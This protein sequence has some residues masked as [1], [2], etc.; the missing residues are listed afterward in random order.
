MGKNPDCASG[1][2]LSQ[3]TNHRYFC[4]RTRKISSCFAQSIGVFPRESFAFGF[5]PWARRSWMIS[6]CSARELAVPPAPV[7]W[8]AR[9]SG[10]EPFSLRA[11]T[12]APSFS[13]VRTADGLRARTARCNGVMPPLS[14]ASKSAPCFA[15]TK[16]V[17]LC[18][19][20]GRTTISV[21]GV[22][23]S[24]LVVVPFRLMDKLETRPTLFGR[25]S[26]A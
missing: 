13:R 23:L 12:V 5:A 3:T 7:D 16:I 8:V 18:R 9:C 2:L 21:L 15:N 26:H 22:R 24:G 25:A 17:W 6:S 14:L 11:S 20:E 19:A 10:V 1:N 4:R